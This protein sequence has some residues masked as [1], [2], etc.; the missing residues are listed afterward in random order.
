MHV[1]RVTRVYDSGLLDVKSIEPGISFTRINIIRGGVA[2]SFDLGDFCVVLQDGPQ[3]YVI[4]KVIQ[5][6]ANR[7]G[8]LSIKDLTDDM[9]DLS[10][11][12]AMT[13]D[14]DIGN[15]ARVVVARGAGVIIDSGENVGSHYDP[16]RGKKFDWSE[17]AEAVM[18]GFSFSIDHNGELCT[19][20]YT[21]RTKVDYESMERDVLYETD[22]SLNENGQTLTLEISDETGAMKFTHYI[23]GVETWSFDVDGTGVMRIKHEHDST[24][25]IE[26]PAM[27]KRT[28]QMIMAAVDTILDFQWIDSMGTPHKLRTDPIYGASNVAARDTLDN[29]T[30]NGEE[31]TFLAFKKMLIE[32]QSS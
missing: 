5:P 23:S 24:H 2:N 29:T 19:T 28:H 20:K 25:D 16:E 13:S 4:G 26:H 22:E 1:G 3:K 31:E 7:N 32:R 6:T 10:G 11:A 14:D 12:L 30:Y 27:S 8:N 18:P 15:Q 9:A 17:R 21:W